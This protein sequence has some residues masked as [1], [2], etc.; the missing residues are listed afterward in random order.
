MRILRDF[1]CVSRMPDR[2][3]AEGQMTVMEPEKSTRCAVKRL[4]EY[5]DWRG[6]LTPRNYIQTPLKDKPSAS[7]FVRL[8]RPSRRP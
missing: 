8:R 6:Q 3:V 1:W 2:H 7:R 5:G 4:A